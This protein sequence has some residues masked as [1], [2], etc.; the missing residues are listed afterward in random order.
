MVS[1][2]IVKNMTQCVDYGSCF[3]ASTDSASCKLLT[4]SSDLSWDT[5]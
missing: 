4:V 3:D 1:D 2:V 5:G